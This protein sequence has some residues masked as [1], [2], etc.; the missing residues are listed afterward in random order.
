MK[1]PLIKGDSVD[2]S[3]DYRDSLPVNM[4]AVNKSIFNSSGY[5]TNFFGLSEFTS[6]AGIDRGSI[7]VSAEGFEGH[8]RVSGN[9]LLS[10]SSEGKVSNLGVIPGFGQ[11]SMDYSF[12]NLAIVSNGKLY[13]Y[14]R[15][16]GL[17]LIKDPDIG[18]P[19][20]LVWVDGYF[21]LTDGKDI[22]HSDILDEEQFL[23]LDF[24]N[25]QF[26]PD[27]SRGLGKNEDNEVVVF[28]E[29]STEY[30][31]NVGTENFAFRRITQKAQKIGLI[32]THAKTELEGVFY[33]LARRKETA[34]S[35]HIISLG[36]E[37]SISTREIDKVLSDYN[38]DELSRVT[39]DSMVIDNSR[40]IVFHLPK[41]TFLFNA[42][43]AKTQGNENSWS[44]LKSGDDVFRA[45]NPI[46]D[47]RNGKWVVG[48]SKSYDIGVFNKD[49]FSQYGEAQNWYLFTPFLKLE[50]LS[51]NK[52]EIETIP[53]IAPDNDAKVF[54]SQTTDGR[55]YTQEWVE[56]YGDNHN[57]QQRFY[58]RNLGYCRN[59]V[60]YRLRG[61]AKCKMSFC[62]LDIEA[63]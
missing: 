61:L 18:S 32:G 1:V 23:P 13:Y 8:Y 60:S 39:V 2:S 63:S 35:F 31:V 50:T 53:G 49:V 19:I 54:L 44:I 15:N 24:G 38:P 16:K 21:F 36:N 56:L 46:L 17:R 45:K 62:N 51:I 28:G 33:T 27:S 48:D 41:N 20:D 43:I 9:S 55:F 47:P 42:S 6:G 5:M 37:K 14:N 58:I 30:F 34:P 52:F 4:Y 11:V 26:I 25:A 3:V 12:N 7:W 59:W 29:F 10:I 22:Y 57:Y 40:F